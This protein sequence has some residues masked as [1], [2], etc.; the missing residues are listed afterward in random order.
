MNAAHYNPASPVNRDLEQ[1]VEPL[2]SYI[3]ATEQPK[4]VLLSALATLVR[5]VRETNQTARSH[6]H[7]FPEVQW[8]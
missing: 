3:C 1:I 6:F 7:N 8:S 4:A 5:A 2:A